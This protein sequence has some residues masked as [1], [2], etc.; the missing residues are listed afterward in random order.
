MPLYVTQDGQATG[1]GG[2]AAADGDQIDVEALKA[3][4]E[5]SHNA[6]PVS[7]LSAS[8][9][10][11]PEMTRVGSKT[12]ATS[13]KSAHSA[14]TSANSASSF[15]HS[16]TMSALSGPDGSFSANAS[17]SFSANASGSFSAG[18]ASFSSLS[19][20]KQQE[21]LYWIEKWKQNESITSAE[22]RCARKGVFP[23][24]G[25]LLG[26]SRVELDTLSQTLLDELLDDAN[27]SEKYGGEME[28]SNPVKPYLRVGFLTKFSDLVM[29][30]AE[31]SSSEEEEDSTLKE[32][33]KEMK[34]QMKAAAR[35][36]SKNVGDLQSLLSS[37]FSFDACVPTL[38]WP[39]PK[40][41]WSRIK[42]AAKKAKGCKPPNVNQSVLQDLLNALGGWISGPHPF[43]STILKSIAFSIADMVKFAFDILLV[44][45]SIASLKWDHW[46]PLENFSLSMK[47]GKMISFFD[48][49]PILGPIANFFLDILGHMADWLS[50]SFS[51]ATRTSCLP[52]LIWYVI[53]VM[54]ATIF[55]VFQVVGGD[56]FGLLVALKYRV[57][58]KQKE[59]NMKEGIE[60]NQ[61]ANLS[62]DE[63]SSEGGFNAN[64]DAGKGEDKNSSSQTAN[65]K[66]AVAKEAVVGDVEEGEVEQLATIPGSEKGDEAAGKSE[67]KK[68]GGSVLTKVKRVCAKA[69]SNL[70]AFVVPGIVKGLT[71][72]LF[73][74]VQFLLILCGSSVQ[75]IY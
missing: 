22:Y 29:K 12:S 75:L 56:M 39:N 40:T 41:L 14:A 34:D 67:E 10:A 42:Q 30:S 68:A 54:L 9:S 7:S 62:S 18:N 6:E 31:E 74:G 44:M 5:G 33:M 43:L 4:K 50:I 38:P 71:A 45:T 1:S 32:Q 52:A 63:G 70:V 57:L 36:L 13:S 26:R 37:Q 2:T 60:Q 23:C 61:K 24:L 25:E 11:V 64:A 65:T 51:F 20:R 19:Q 58:V 59:A 17:G 53:C 28:T 15:S 21:L 55:V 73:I 66:E 46:F 8:D 35:Q 72:T 27:Y 47:I 3:L 48:L 49:V 16:I 69:W